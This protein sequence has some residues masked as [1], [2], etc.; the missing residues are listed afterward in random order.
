MEVKYLATINISDEGWDVN[1][2]E[3]V[4]WEAGQEAGRVLFLRALRQIEEKVLAQDSGEKK[5]K[6]RHYLTIRLGAI[7]FYRQKVKQDGEG[8]A[9]Y[10]CPLD[11]AIGLESYQE[12]TLWVKRRACELSVDHTY[13][14]AARLLSQ[15]VG[16]EVS[17]RAVHRWVQQQGRNLREEEDRRWEGVFERGEQ[18]ESDG[19]G[20]EI[21]VSELDA[22]MIHSQEKGEKNI[23]V[24][25]GVMYSGKELESDKAKHQ[26][27]RLQEKTLYGG[28]D[29]AE[30]FGEKLYLKGEER[31][32]LSRA[33]NMLLVGDG[34]LWIKGIAENPYFMAN[35]QLD[36]WHLLRKIR[37]T[38]PD[39]PGVVTELEDYLYS[40]EG[41]ELLNTVKLAKLLSGDKERE[42]RIGEL[43]SYIEGNLGGLYGARALRD[44]VSAKEMLVTSSGAVEKNIEVVIG[45]RFKRR[46]MCWTREG[47]QNL[48]KLRI[49][50]YDKEDW[51]AFWQRQAGLGVSLSPN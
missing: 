47:A 2:L 43:A 8:K 33:R 38:F 18:V 45:R 15:E 36:Y 16:T 14:E 27:Y 13:R 46:G 25:L 20:R 51:S 9:R 40:G 34:D 24:K 11:K 7:T 23:V 31:L 19:E 42:A 28:I 10:S 49:L 44:K 26:R 35:Y 32:S 22:T 37:Q 29:E 3:K 17:H 21:V 30:E 50:R 12:T 1:Q 4:C 5:G 39:E 48:L 41:K 6:V